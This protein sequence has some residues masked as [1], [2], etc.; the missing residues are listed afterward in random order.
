MVARNIRYRNR[1]YQRE[2]GT[3]GADMP[4]FPRAQTLTRTRSTTS[5]CEL[6]KASLITARPTR[7][8]S[9][10]HSVLLYEEKRYTMP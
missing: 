6:R 4:P 10:I 9:E 8:R 7:K 3:R 2:L 1:R 5:M